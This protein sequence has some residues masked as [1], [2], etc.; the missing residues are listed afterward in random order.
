MKQ[1]LVLISL[2]SLAFTAEVHIDTSS[3]VWRGERY[4]ITA[5]CEGNEVA[6]G[7]CGSGRNDDCGSNI[8]HKLLCCDLDAYH[9]ENCMVHGGPEGSYLD[10]TALDGAPDRLLEGACGSGAGDD[11]PGETSHTVSHSI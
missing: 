8:W 6:W 7:Q 4:G 9:F 11:C 2:L 1:F 3:C 5:Q 10:C